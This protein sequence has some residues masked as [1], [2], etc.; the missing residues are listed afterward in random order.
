M[1]K[2][3]N[4]IQFVELLAFDYWNPNMG[5]QTT[6]NI[7]YKNDTWY[8]IILN[9]L[10][11]LG[12]GAEDAHL[13][14]LAGVRSYYFFPSKVVSCFKVLLGNFKT[15]IASLEVVKT[16]ICLLRSALLWTTSTDTLL[17][18]KLLAWDLQ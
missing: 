14:L 3:L 15:L 18:I 12:T 10:L 13:G 1:K 4:R 6:E 11:F 2:H 7:G 5:T 8:I 17:I 9:H 16:T